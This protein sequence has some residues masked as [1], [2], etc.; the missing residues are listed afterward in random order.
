MK[1]NFLNEL[2]ND[3][4]VLSLYVI[5]IIIGFMWIS[6][7]IRKL[8]TRS[9]NP[10]SDFNDFLGQIH[11]MADSNP[12]PIFSSLINTYLVANYLILTYIV[13]ILEIFLGISVI[14]GLFSRIG[15]VIGLGYT[16]VLFLSTLGWGEWIW[17][18]PLIATPMLI[19]FISSFKTRFGFDF[20]LFEKYK[21][22]KFIPL[23]I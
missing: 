13:I 4:N 5:R 20:I 15:C 3:P 19:I 14:F 6:E 7:A 10:T 2:K 23:L 16:I 11:H 17:T 8:V 21:N 18:Y 1:I 12:Y 22:K 9:S